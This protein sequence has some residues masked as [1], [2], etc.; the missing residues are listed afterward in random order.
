[1]EKGRVV[2]PIFGAKLA[3]PIL[4]SPEKK[5]VTQLEKKTGRRS[6]PLK[7]AGRSRMACIRLKQN[8]TALA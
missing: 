8:S 1:M 5:M 4:T 6:S 3:C 7:G 2:P